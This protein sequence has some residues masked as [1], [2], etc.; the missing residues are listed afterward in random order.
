M[1][2]LETAPLSLH[3]FEGPLDYLIHLVQRGEIDIYDVPLLLLTEQFVD[4][5]LENSDN[6]LEVGAEF[7][8]IASTLVWLKS[9][10]LLPQDPNAQV[11]I[12]EETA[13]ARF[14]IIHQLL[15][16]CRF[17]KAG[18]EFIQREQQQANLRYRTPPTHDVPRPN[19]LE[20]LP[21]QE[22]ANLFENVLKRAASSTGKVYEE[23]FRVSD[24]M[25]SLRLRLKER[26][27]LL[28]DEVFNDVM[29]REE[30]IVTFLA[31][32]ELMKN[33]D[34]VSMYHE[35]SGTFRILTT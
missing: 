23:R 7:V 27:F 1:N 25:K 2:I 11:T 17:K 22:L 6:S 14:N 13:D 4:R 31:L 18:Q 10:R 12:E 32:L 19:G 34:L 33:G 15:E 24:A 29:C 35:D 8:G 20:H 30:L 9:K 16:Y 28:F 5:H 3:N 21:L 26:E